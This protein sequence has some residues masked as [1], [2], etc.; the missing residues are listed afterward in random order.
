MKSHPALDKFRLPVHRSADGLLLGVMSGFA[1]R[2]GWKIWLTRVV[3]VFVL[4]SIPGVFIRHASGD[5]YG[6]GFFYLLLA[7]FMLPP[8]RAGEV[9][10]SSSNAA[11]HEPDPDSTPG[12]W[13]MARRAG[14]RFVPTFPRDRENFG[15]E[16]TTLPV[17]AG[18]RLDL[19]ALDRQLESLNRRIARMEGIVT[20]R[21]YDWD[22]R[23]RRE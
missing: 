9:D 1:E 12:S 23:L 11:N 2:F 5:L 10:F 14:R 8:A 7:V 17:G 16:T 4:L 19:Q 20:R 15:Q 22:D 18:G 6:A 13:V 3:G 21:E